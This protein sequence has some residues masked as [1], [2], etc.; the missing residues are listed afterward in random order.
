[1]RKSNIATDAGEAGRAL[2]LAI[3]A[4]RDSPTLT[5]R[6]RAVA[7]RQQALAHALQGELAACARTLDL[8]VEQAEEALRPNAGHEDAATYCTPAYIAS[9]AGLCWLRLGQPARAVASLQHS[10]RSWPSGTNGRDRDLALARLALAHTCARDIEQAC[11]VTTQAVASA[12]LIRSP[13]AR[14]ALGSIRN[15]LLPARRVPLVASTLAALD[16]LPTDCAS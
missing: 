6:L 4:T 2:G 10:L 15:E 12:S 14:A 11:A 1:M 7:L 5:P 8:A 3:A 9:E 16:V 13:R